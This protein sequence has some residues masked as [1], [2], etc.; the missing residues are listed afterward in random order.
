MITTPRILLIA[1]L[2]SFTVAAQALIIFEDDF[3]SENGGSSAINYD[4]FANWNV[5]NGSVDIVSSGGWGL[6]GDGSFVD[7]DGSTSDSGR[8][9]SK[10]RFTFESGVNYRFSFRLSGDQRNDGENYIRSIITSI[11]VPLDGSVPHYVNQFIAMDS[12]DGWTDYSFDFLGQ[13][14]DGRIV[15]RADIRDNYND[16]V[17]LLLDDVVLETVEVPE[18]GTIALLGLGLLGLTFSR[19]FQKA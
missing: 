3:N 10:Q 19:R 4:S 1:L 12:N 5:V 2:S 9:V 13:G 8:L 7:L 17:G 16:N 6:S 15:F 18:P 14:L 11:E